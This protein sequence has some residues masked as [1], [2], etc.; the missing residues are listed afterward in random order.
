MSEPN[1][2]VL[3]GRKPV[4][5]GLGPAELGTIKRDSNVLRKHHYTHGVTCRSYRDATGRF[6]KFDDCRAVNW[7]EIGILLLLAGI[8]V[9]WVYS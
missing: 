7:M 4:K 9:A 5:S 2:T 8:L 6:A 3:F 1:I